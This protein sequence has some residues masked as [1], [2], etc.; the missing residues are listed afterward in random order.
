MLAYHI[1]AKQKQLH[2]DASKCWIQSRNIFAGSNLLQLIIHLLKYAVTKPIILFY[3]VI[4][5][6]F[7]TLVTNIQQ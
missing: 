7:L 4:F 3:N 1:I 6:I 5:L 2:E